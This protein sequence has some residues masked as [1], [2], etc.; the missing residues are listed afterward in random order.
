MDQ[1]F[2]IKS[3]AMRG[4]KKENEVKVLPLLTAAKCLVFFCP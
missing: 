1:L 4:L 2:S 3:R